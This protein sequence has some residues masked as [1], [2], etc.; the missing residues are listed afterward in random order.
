MDR[1]QAASIERAA[2]LDSRSATGKRSKAAQKHPPRYQA[3]RAVAA[4]GPY[5]DGIGI[6]SMMAKGPPTVVLSD[7]SAC[8]PVELR[9]DDAAGLAPP[10]PLEGRLEARPAKRAAGLVEV[11][12]PRNDAEPVS[13]GVG[14]NRLP[15]LTRAHERFVSA[16]CDLASSDEAV[17]SISSSVGFMSDRES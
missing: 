4:D 2:L 9:R 14:L 15:L 8:E 12:V 1:E 6:V 5:R 10:A 13:S 7:G 11:F 16:S 3:R 17:S